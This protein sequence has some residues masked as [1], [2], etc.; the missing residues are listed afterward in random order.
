VNV[1]YRT[2]FDK[3][4]VSGQ[5]TICRT[6]STFTLVMTDSTAQ[7]FFLVKKQKSETGRISVRPADDV[8]E[9]LDVALG[10]TQQNMSTLINELLREYLPEV[11]RKRR[12]VIESASERIDVLSGRVG[13]A[14]GDLLD[15]AAQSLRP[16]P[17]TGAPTSQASKP[18][19]SARRA[20]KSR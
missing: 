11:V 16:K 13:T 12:D 7:D 6:Y 17:A 19:P 5:L 8:R 10:A 18:K 14:A 1:C 20:K 9:M 4:N 2:Q 15:G 3:T